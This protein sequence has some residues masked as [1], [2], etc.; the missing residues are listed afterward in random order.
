[1]LRAAFDDVFHCL[2]SS[3]T[4]AWAVI[5]ELDCQEEALEAYLVGGH[6]ND[7][8]ANSP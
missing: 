5:M 1:M 7:Q 4:W 8:G 6:L 3:A 2:C